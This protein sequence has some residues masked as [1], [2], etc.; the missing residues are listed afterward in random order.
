MKPRRKRDFSYLASL[1]GL[2]FIGV[3]PYQGAQ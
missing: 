3:Q 2:T 1:A